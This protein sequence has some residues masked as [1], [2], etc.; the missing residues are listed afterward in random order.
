MA[1]DGN[2]VPRAF[3]DRRGGPMDRS[4]PGKNLLCGWVTDYKNSRDLTS[5][6]PPHGFSSEILG[7]MPHLPAAPL[8]S[9]DTTQPCL[10]LLPS[11]HHLLTSC[12]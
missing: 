4:P 10:L 11:D 7:P 6:F 12:F 8:P 3:V 1:V 2:R 5:D 9:G